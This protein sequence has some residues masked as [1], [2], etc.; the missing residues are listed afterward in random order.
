[1]NNAVQEE[2]LISQPMRELQ[3]NSRPTFQVPAG[4]CDAHMHVFAALEQ[5]P[6]VTHPHYTLP[7]GDV[8]HFERLIGYLGLSRYVIVQPS[9]YGTDNRCMVDTLNRLGGHV[10]G[11][12]MVEEDVSET[13]LDELHR[14]GVRAL[15]LDLF[16]RSNLSTEAI[17]AYILRMAERIAARGWHLQFY[18]P[19]WV[20]KNLIPF[21]ATLRTPFVIDHMGYMLEEDGLGADDFAQL[22]EVLKTG[23]CWL[24]LS[25]PY[26]IAKK[27]SLD[28]VAPM[29]KAII[30]AAPDRVI[31]GSDWPHIPDSGRDTG[32]LL[33]LL[34]Q[35]TDDP[36]V[37]KAILVDNPQVLFDFDK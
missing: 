21:F 23:Y 15:R 35:W 32:E 37:I 18:V 13:A 9:F 25:A 5:Y 24:K 20:V 28:V 10:R 19:G 3:T 17:Q 2:P 1:M 8:E 6:C 33:N 31:W 22:L 12:A 26:R 34:G 11:V 4:A 30:A 27:R 14:A 16:K 36:E 29:A 7:E